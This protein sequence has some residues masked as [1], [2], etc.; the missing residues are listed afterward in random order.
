MGERADRREDAEPAEGWLTNEDLLASLGDTSLSVS[1]LKR[2]RADGLMPRPVQEHVPGHRGSVTFWPP[3][4]DLQLAAVIRL[5]DE[6][7]RHASVLLGLWWEGWDVDETM[8]RSELGKVL[9]EGP[10]SV[11]LDGD[12]EDARLD[13]LAAKV[14]AVDVARVPG[15]IGRMIRRVG[16]AEADRRSLVYTIVAIG[17]GIDIPLDTDPHL[18]DD[19]RSLADIV[20][21]GLDLNGRAAALSTDQEPLTAPDLLETVARLSTDSSDMWEAAREAVAHGDWDQLCG[22]RDVGRTLLDG[23]ERVARYIDLVSPGHPAGSLFAG[24]D[25]PLRGRVAMGLVVAIWGRSALPDGIAVVVS[26]IEQLDEKAKAFQQVLDAV[27]GL[28][29]VLVKAAGDQGRLER[30]AG[31]HLEM[32]EAMRNF[33]DCHP[34]IAAILED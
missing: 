1:Q 13:D 19:E 23:G 20:T 32:Q 30:L 5:R 17:L 8:L 15:P 33:M 34:E 21:T 11:H 9:A 25:M 10:D 4:A 24:V 28:R 2:M 26:S 14:D 16:P 27:P 7:R 3:G 22:A 12:D 31:E 18:V 6:N 29:E